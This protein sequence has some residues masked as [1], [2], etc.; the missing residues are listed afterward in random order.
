MRERWGASDNSDCRLL[1]A[2]SPSLHT[3]SRYLAPRSIYPPRLQSV[4]KIQAPAPSLER[5]RDDLGSA[6]TPCDPNPSDEKTC[7]VAGLESRGLYYFPK[8]VSLSRG[9]IL[10]EGRVLVPNDPGSFGQD[11]RHDLR[12]ERGGKSGVIPRAGW[13]ARAPRRSLSGPGFAKAGA[14]RRT[15]AS[16][17]QACP[18]VGTPWRRSRPAW[19][20]PGSGACSR[21]T[22]LPPRGPRSRLPRSW[23]SL[24]TPRAT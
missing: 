11:H 15:S 3:K 1:V 20:R 2:R 17:A 5:T 7:G 10:P 18:S 6:K 14:A 9:V 19:L 4:S 16:W 22:G 23:R 12:E 13:P 24:A 8:V 21:S